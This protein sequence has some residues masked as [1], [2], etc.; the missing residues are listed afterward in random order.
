MHSILV[1]NDHKVIMNT[2]YTHTHTHTHTHSRSGGRIG[3][4]ILSNTCMG[5]GVEVLARLDFR[6][7]GLQFNNV[8]EPVNLDDSFHMGYVFMMLIAD[9]IVYYILAW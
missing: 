8:I 9:S 2:H 4:C 5:L 1:I 3:A 6:Q 7:E